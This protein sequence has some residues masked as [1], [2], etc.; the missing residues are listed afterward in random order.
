M[1]TT[2][3]GNSA[4]ENQGSMNESSHRI[5]I[6]RSSVKPIAAMALIGLAACQR[7]RASRHTQALDAAPS[8]SALH[9]AGAEAAPIASAHPAADAGTRAPKADGHCKARGSKGVTEL[10]PILESA[11]Q[12]NAQPDAIYALGYTHELARVR[13]YRFSRQGGP[14]EVVSE[15]KGIG[16][17]KGFAVAD[18]AGYYSQAGRLFK[19]GPQKGASSTLAETVYSPVAV[20][21]DQVL[22]IQCDRKGKVN[23]L[24]SVSTSGGEPKMIAELDHRVGEPCQYSAIV[25]DER[26]VY[27]ADWTGQQIFDVSRADGNVRTIVTKRGFPG[28][29]ILEPDKLVYNSVLGL[30]QIARDGSNPTRIADN[31]VAMAPYSLILAN[32]SSYW[33]FDAFAYNHPTTLRRL[34]R[35]GGAAQSFMV[36]HNAD[37]DAQNWD[38]DGLVDFVVDDECVYVG[39]T[40]F[41]RPG[42][43]ILAKA[44]E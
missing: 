23:R 32:Q 8:A 18:G 1:V 15:Q 39:Q 25:A 29:L 35:T 11:L 36:L 41:K 2:V 7:E 13:L 10:Q 31:S 19:L 9:D 38:G 5:R 44:F 22:S 24:I 14:V 43:R 20:V 30:Y 28:P 33:V 42:V 4:G 6:K 34:A 3:L 26:D 12:L 17:L 21:A 40:Q 16:T 27:V 37:P